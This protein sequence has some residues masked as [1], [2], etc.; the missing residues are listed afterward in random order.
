MKPIG[1]LNRDVAPNDQQPGT[2]RHAKNILLTKLNQAVATEPGN[3]A[4]YAKSGWLLVGTIPVRNEAVVLFYV[5]DDYLTDS[6]ALSSIVYLD[7]E[8]TAVTVVTHVDLNFSPEHPFKGV[9]YY[10]TKDNLVIAWTDN[11]NPPR[12]LNVSDP[13][14]ITLE[15][16]VVSTTDLNGAFEDFKAQ[17][18]VMPRISFSFPVNDM[19]TF[20][21]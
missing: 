3:S 13:T 20:S 9:Y 16:S 21:F 18:N 4:E 5:E 8:G 2:Y 10:N 17:I 12:I 14:N 1:G 15:G 19:A 6:N 7:K 11:N